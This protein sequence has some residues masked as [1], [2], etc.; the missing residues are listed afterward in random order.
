MLRHVPA[1]RLLAAG[2]LLMLAREHISKLQPHE[3]RRVVE[4]LRRARGRPR[5]LSRRER[6]ELAELVEKAEPRL[7]MGEA[8][9]KLTGVPLPGRQHRDKR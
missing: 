1:A 9:K 4:L 5:N 6:H 7:F 2:E 8:V 3:R